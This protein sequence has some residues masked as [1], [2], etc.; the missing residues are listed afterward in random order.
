[1]REPYSLVRS[2]VLREGSA[3]AEVPA[4]C[5]RCGHGRQRSTR[6]MSGRCRGCTS[7]TVRAD[8]RWGPTSRPHPAMRARSPAE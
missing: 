5:H 4:A 8:G 3:N 6:G 7:G 1:V 2:F